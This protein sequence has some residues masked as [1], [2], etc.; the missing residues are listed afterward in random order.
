MQF[1]K[2]ERHV[3]LAVGLFLLPYVVGPLMPAVGLLPANP[4]P[5]EYWLIG[6]SNAILRIVA[7]SGFA[8]W[9]YDESKS[10]VWALLG[11]VFGPIGFVIYHLV[12]KRK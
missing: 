6:L 1:T 5:A 3:V 11:I 4:Q 8:Y 10:M 9:I 2:T 12:E 7:H